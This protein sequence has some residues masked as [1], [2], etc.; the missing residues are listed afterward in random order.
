MHDFY[1]D[2]EHDAGRFERFTNGGYVDDMRPTRAEA[3]ADE[4]YLDGGDDK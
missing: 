2:T 1:T 3:E 4:R